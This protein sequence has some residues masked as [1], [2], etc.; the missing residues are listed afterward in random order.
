TKKNTMAKLE[1]A[2]PITAVHG[3]MDRKSRFGAAKRSMRNQE[4]ES[5]P[6]SV[7]YGVRLS[8]P[9][10]DELAAQARFGAV[11]TAVKLRKLDPNKT[12]TDAAAFK[13]QSTY[14]TMQAYLWHV[15]G[16]EYDAAHAG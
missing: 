3:V 2:Y 13:A 1:Y 4:G 8:Q 16:D 12:R 9:S 11:A 14:K 15:C 10:E 6:Y 7:R 5:K